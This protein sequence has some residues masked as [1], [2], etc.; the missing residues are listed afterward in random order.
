M[1]FS[2]GGRLSVDGCLGLFDG[3]D[4]GFGSGGTGFPGQVVIVHS[5][6]GVVKHLSF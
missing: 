5:G 2:V 6:V 4:N 1:D 3:L